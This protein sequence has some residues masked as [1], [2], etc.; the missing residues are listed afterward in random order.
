V[1]TVFCT[2]A[3]P[4]WRGIEHGLDLVKKGIIWRVRSGSKIRIW[5]DPWV[6][7]PSSLRLTLKKGRSQL[8]WVYQLMKSDR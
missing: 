1:D 8:K 6:P 5:R 2:D 3:S 4:T 7:R